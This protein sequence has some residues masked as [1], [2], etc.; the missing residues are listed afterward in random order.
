MGDLIPFRRRKTKRAWTSAQDYG[1][2]PP[3]KPPRPSWRSTLRT[4]WPPLALV[5][6][7]TLWALYRN[8]LLF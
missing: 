7:A 4:A 8:G 3:A 2:P 6:A 1:A 5:A